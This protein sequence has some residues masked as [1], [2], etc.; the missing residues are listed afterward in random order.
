M[1]V[2]LKVRHVPPFSLLLLLLLL[3]L[4]PPSCKREEGEDL[5]HFGGRREE[6]AKWP[7]AL[8]RTNV[9]SMAPPSLYIRNFDEGSRKAHFPPKS[10]L[11]THLA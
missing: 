4:F 8:R 11:H 10:D 7:R 6:G 1:K 9:I 5:A 3:L 2:H